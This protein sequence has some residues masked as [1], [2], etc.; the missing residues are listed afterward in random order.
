M[1]QEYEPKSKEN[2]LDSREMADIGK[3]R[4][5]ELH[6]RLERKSPE[7][8]PEKNKERSLEDAR[9]ET[10]KITSEKE[11]PEPAHNQ[12]K[13]IDDAPHQPTKQ[14]KQAKYNEIMSETRQQMSPSSRTFSK[15][16]H[17]PAIEKTSDFTGKTIARPN[18][19]LAGSVSAFVLVLAVYLVANYYGYALS[20]TETILAFTLGW[21]IGLVFDYFKAMFTGGSRL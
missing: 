6:E 14:L 11:S 18:A 16:I 13:S 12:E 3:E 10:E 17:N 9:H 15:V 8:N 1:S 2:L 5:A 4:Q 20:G 7:R 21:I 19:I